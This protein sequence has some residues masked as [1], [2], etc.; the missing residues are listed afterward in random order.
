GNNKL[1]YQATK[2]NEFRWHYLDLSD[3]SDNA[4]HSI[5]GVGAD[6]IEPVDVLEIDTIRAI[7]TY[8]HTSGPFANKTLI[9][10]YKLDT[11]AQFQDMGAYAGRNHET[12]G[13]QLPAT[14]Y[15]DGTR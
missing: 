2:T 1:Y 13:G 6:P 7:V 8:D 3:D 10:S 14:V 12:S 11:S 9:Y 5:T 4:V 15:G